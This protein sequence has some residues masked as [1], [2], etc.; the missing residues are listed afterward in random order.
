[1]LSEYR[2][3]FYAI[4]TL[5]FGWLGISLVYY[6]IGEIIGRSVGYLL[7]SALISLITTAISFTCLRDEKKIRANFGQIALLIGTITLWIYICQ[8]TIAAKITVL[9]YGYDNYAHLAQSRTILM[10]VSTNLLNVSPTLPTFLSNTAQGS[11]AG[12]AFLFSA[13][14]HH[15]HL[16]SHLTIFLF[17]T[18]M[19][20]IILLLTLYSALKVSGVTPKLVIPAVLVFAVHTVWVYPSHIW[21]SGY[22]ASSV[23]TI[24]LVIIGMEFNSNPTRHRLIQLLQ[25]IVLL[26]VYPLLAIPGLAI[27]FVLNRKYIIRDL[28]L[29]PKLKKSQLVIL[30]FNLAIAVPLMALPFIAMRRS[31]GSS[32]FLTDGGIETFPLFLYFYIFLVMIMMSCRLARRSHLGMRSAQALVICGLISTVLIIYSIKNTDRVQYYPTK[33]IIVLFIIC[34]GLLLI[35]IVKTGRSTLESL[36]SLAIVLCLAFPLTAQGLSPYQETFRSGFMGAVPKVIPAIWDEKI[37]VVDGTVDKYLMERS[38]VNNKAILYISARVESELNSRWINSLS[39]KWNDSSWGS[40]MK[41]STFI[42]D[43]AYS[44]ADDLMVENNLSLAIEKS[45]LFGTKI[46]AE[47]SFPK[48]AKTNEICFLA[49]PTNPICS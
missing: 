28:V 40:W 30:G 29:I 31:V 1:V 26:N 48:L 42:K 36:V 44:S 34:L 19:L 37:E 43:Q 8:M 5:V 15:N 46:M 45:D 41:A 2:N 23:G 25:F 49:D 9:G 47:N 20:P 17:L 24:L 3:I 38:L 35:Q 6:L 12:L 10:D 7:P 21:F 11:S 4:K 39:G 14:D 27:Y 18:F 33:I 16:N 22:F 13:I 32:T